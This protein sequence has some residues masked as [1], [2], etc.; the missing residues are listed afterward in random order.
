MGVEVLSADSSWG[1]KLLSG[2]LSG[3]WR[4][5]S[6][7]LGRN[8]HFLSVKPVSKKLVMEARLT[9]Q[10]RKLCMCLMARF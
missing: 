2:G 7:Q 4:A 3:T 5:A 1:D 10:N 6:S 8:W 9:K